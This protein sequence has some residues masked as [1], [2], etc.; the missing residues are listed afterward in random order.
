MPNAF[1]WIA[2]LPGVF[3]N[4][5]FGQTDRRDGSYCRWFLSISSSLHVFKALLMV[6]MLLTISVIHMPCFYI[7]LGIIKYWP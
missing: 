6:K 7:L 2:S 3:G 5:K 1:D 4:G